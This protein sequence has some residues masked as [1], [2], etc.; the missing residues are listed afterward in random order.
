MKGLPINQTDPLRMQIACLCTHGGLTGVPQVSIPGATIDGL[1]VGMS[2]I[3][4]WGTDAQLTALA[5]A[6]ENSA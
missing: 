2:I 1:P 5:L 3:G 6:M 4:R